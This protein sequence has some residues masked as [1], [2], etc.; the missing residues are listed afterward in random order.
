VRG[1]KKRR[2]VANEEEKGG[3][4]E[5]VVSGEKK[6]GGGGP[7]SFHSDFWLR[8]EKNASHTLMPLYGKSTGG[9]REK[10]KRGR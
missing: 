5:I 8:N 1:K 6:K 4:W 3:G 7:V 9:E 2:P 10:K